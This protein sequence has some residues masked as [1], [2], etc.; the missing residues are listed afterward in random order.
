MIL[1]QQVLCPRLGDKGVS[2]QVRVSM[3]DGC[4][5]V[6][7]TRYLNS[8][9]LVLKKLVFGGNTHA[10][11]HTQA[12]RHTCVEASIVQMLQLNVEQASS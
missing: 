11:A 9:Y 1:Y 5:L 7:G 2:A 8:G 6:W 4:W 3:W 10:H 12:Q